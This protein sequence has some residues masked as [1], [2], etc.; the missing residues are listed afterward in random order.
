MR[1][2]PSSLVCSTLLALLGAACGGSCVTG[3]TP[4][5]AVN[6]ATTPSGAVGTTVII[7]GQNFGNAPGSVLF[8]NGAGGTVTATI[9]A[10]ADWTAGFIVTTVPAGAGTGPLVVQAAGGSSSPV[11][12]TIVQKVLF[13]PSTVSWTATSALPRGLSGH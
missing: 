6:G 13:S 4:P 7:E 10:P 3:P 2:F 1:A 11:T 12:F 5:P 9:A 8:S